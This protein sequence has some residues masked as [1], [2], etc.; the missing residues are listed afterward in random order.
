V[1]FHALSRAGVEVD[2]S[3]NGGLALVRAG[4]GEGGADGLTAFDPSTG[5][6]TQFLP[7]S[8]APSPRVSSLVMVGPEPTGRAVGG[9]AEL[10]DVSTSS[11]PPYA[12][13]AGGLAAAAVVLTAGAWYARRRWGR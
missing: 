11:A 1:A 10:P 4:G 3:A 2:V 5:A 12:V 13:L 8:G 7:L 9:I 6:A